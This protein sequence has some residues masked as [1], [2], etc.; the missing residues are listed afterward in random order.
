MSSAWAQ[1][2]G[3]GETERYRLVV[4]FYSAGGGID[5]ETKQTFMQ[6]LTTYQNQNGVELDYQEFYWGM[7]GEITLGFKLKE[8]SDAQQRRFIHNL[9]MILKEG[10][11][12]DMAENYDMPP[13]YIVPDRSVD[14]P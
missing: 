1:E 3:W 12:F 5:R 7:E 4:A 2:E 11:Q 6:F 14:V 9:K 13:Y 10:R 8:L